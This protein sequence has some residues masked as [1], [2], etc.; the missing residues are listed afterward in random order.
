M[1]VWL[2]WE[3]GPSTASL[4]MGSSTGSAEKGIPGSACPTGSPV[5]TTLILY[6][7]LSPGAYI[8]QVLTV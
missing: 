8:H 1:D 3:P 6:G 7:R 2:Q 5:I 4:A